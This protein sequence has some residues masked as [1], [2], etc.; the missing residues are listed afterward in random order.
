MERGE[1][2]FSPQD[3]IGQ[4]TMRNLDIADTRAKLG[5]YA[6]TG[7]FPWKIFWVWGLRE[8]QC[9]ATD[10]GSVRPS[11]CRPLMYG[12]DRGAPAS[13]LGFALPTWRRDSHEYLSR[14][15]N[16]ETT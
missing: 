5:V 4:L 15:L 3:R 16:N 12:V 6:K 14:R 8:R 9:S 7:L 13:T 10:L 11:R 1:S 2:A